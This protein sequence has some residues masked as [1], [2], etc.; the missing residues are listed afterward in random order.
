MWAAYELTPPPEMMQED[1]VRF[2]QEEVF[3]AVYMSPTRVAGIT[4]LHLLTTRA[5]EKYLWVIESFDLVPGQEEGF[6]LSRTEEARQKLESSGTLISGLS[7]FYDVVATR[8]WPAESGSKETG[9]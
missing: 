5:A 2:V 7:P 8:V 3:P 9:P 1:F 4:G 6:V